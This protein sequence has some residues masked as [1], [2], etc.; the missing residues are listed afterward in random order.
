MNLKLSLTAS[1][2]PIPF[3]KPPYTL[4]PRK[5]WRIVC[6]WKTSAS[7]EVPLPCHYSVLLL[8]KWNQCLTF[9]SL[10]TT[11][12]Y[13]TFNASE[14][15]KILSPVIK[16]KS[17]GIQKL[18]NVLH[19]SIGIWQVSTTSSSLHCFFI[20]HSFTVHQQSSHSAR[21]IVKC[22]NILDAGQKAQDDQNPNPHEAYSLTESRN[23]KPRN[24]WI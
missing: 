19:G 17:W 22:F 18:N 14:V 24:K 8:I 6:T 2:C 3:Q 16:C 5:C 20:L 15:C 13:F 1:P 4:S 21:H 10:Q 9:L 23:R 7:W 12:H 11:T